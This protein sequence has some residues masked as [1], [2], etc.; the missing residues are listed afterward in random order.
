M[1]KTV[2]LRAAT[3]VALTVLLLA[4]VLAGAVPF[5]Q[6]GTEA[7]SF[8]ITLLTP[9]VGIG[10]LVLA[11]FAIFGKLSWILVGCTA[12]AVVGVFGNDQVVSMF[13]GWFGV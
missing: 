12:I 2:L 1:K 11:A 6:A 3:G 9:V 13:R 4:P 8:L 7:K 10:L 5:V